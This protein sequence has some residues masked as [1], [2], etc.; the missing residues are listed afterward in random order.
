M[1]LGLEDEMAKN[2]RE[3]SARTGIRI[4]FMIE[5]A[6]AEYFAKH[7]LLDRDTTTTA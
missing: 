4:T 2:L 6:L 5:K 7:K 3:I 1:S